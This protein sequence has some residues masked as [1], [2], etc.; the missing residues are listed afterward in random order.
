MSSSLLED[1]KV[2]VRAKLSALWTSLMF[3]YV[4]GDYFEF[5]VPGKLQDMLQGKMGP[6]GPVSQGMLVATSIV[7]LVPSLMIFLS[8]V[9]PPAI[10][11]WLNVGVGLLYTLLVLSIMAEGAWAFYMLLA[12]VEGVLTSLVVWYAW[13]WPRS[14]R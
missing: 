3:C 5:Y 6:V 12:G 1:M 10:S 9:L 11:R 13:R 8:L 7:M 14:G 4:Y 2:P